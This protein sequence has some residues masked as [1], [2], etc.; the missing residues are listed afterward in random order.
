MASRAWKSIGSDEPTPTIRA[1]SNVQSNGNSTLGS[2]QVTGRLE[3]AKKAKPNRFDAATILFAL[4]KLYERCLS[5]NTDTLRP[6]C[7]NTSTI[8]SK[9]SYRG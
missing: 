3:P 6:S 2:R 7:S 9:N 4:S 1:S 8:C 5:L